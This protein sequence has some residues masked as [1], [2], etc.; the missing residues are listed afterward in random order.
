MLQSL[1][2][3]IAMALTQVTVPYQANYDFGVGA[4][5]ATASPMGLAVVGD[6]SGVTNSSGAKTGFQISRI[7]SFSDLETSLGISVEAS[8]GCGCFSASARFDYAKSAKIQSS[9][10]FVAITS[11]VQLENL[12]IDDPSLSPAAAALI[13]NP[14]L[15]ASRFGNMFVRGVAR[16]GLFVAVMRFDTSSSEEA[17]SISAELSGS[18]GA[19]SGDAKSKMSKVQRKFRSELFISV[20]HEGGPVDLVMGDISDGNQLLL[21][22]DNWLHALQADP[23]KNSVPYNVSLAPIAIANG[24][25]PPNPQQVQ[26]AQDI[27]VICAKQRS[28]VLDGMNLMDYIIQHPARY[29]FPPPTTRDDVVKAFDGY[30]SDL[31][32]IASAASQAINDVANAITPADYAKT[33]NTAY[34]LGIPPAPV[35][36]LKKGDMDT[37]A[38][39]GTILIDQ[40]PLAGTLRDQQPE[41]EARRGFLIG[42]GISERQTEEGPVKTATGQSLPEA[43]RRGFLIAVHYSLTRNRAIEWVEKGAKVAKA[44]PAVQTAA[45]ENTNVFYCLGFEVATGLFGDP[46]LGGA[47]HTSVGV[48]ALDIRTKLADPDAQR[49]FDDGVKFHLGPP[50]RWSTT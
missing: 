45:T 36:E 2:I 21:M 49:G 22:L 30:Q 5:L 39:K 14:D 26:H 28:Q 40:D 37:L 50:Q 34:P 47:G 13:D 6:V 42:M 15:F 25:I 27:L 19:F 38:A 3:G 20:Y 10:L 33:K 29:D 43:Q 32:V 17:E 23:A 44:D 8:G 9:S 41:G 31:D 12:S 18:Y 46:K 4:D 11:T 1:T 16:G 48:G 24:P 7:T 35:P